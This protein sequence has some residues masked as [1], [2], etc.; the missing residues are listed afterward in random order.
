[1]QMFPF[2]KIGPSFDGLAVTKD[3]DNGKTRFSQSVE[4]L[5]YYVLL[6]I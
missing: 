2:F 5:V 4:F 3:N 1:M 6:G